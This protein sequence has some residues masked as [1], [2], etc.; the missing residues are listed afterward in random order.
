MKISHIVTYNA[1]SKCLTTNLTKL[2]GSTII[3]SGGGSLPTTSSFVTFRKYHFKSLRKS[4]PPCFYMKFVDFAIVLP[5]AYILH[6][7]FFPSMFKC[8]TKRKTSSISLFVAPPSRNYSAAIVVY[9][10]CMLV[11]A[12]IY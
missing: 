1:S 4:N 9:A 10:M 12:S 2:S 8:T 11:Y 7:V 3:A 6:N 5:I